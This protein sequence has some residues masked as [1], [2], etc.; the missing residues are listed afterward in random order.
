ME[1]SVL[2]DGRDGVVIVVVE[3]GRERRH[4][5]VLATDD[6]AATEAAVRAAPRRTACAPDRRGRAVSRLLMV[7]VVW[8][9]WRAM[10]VLLLSAAHV[11]HF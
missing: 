11:I 1:R 6:V 4:R 3:R 8:L 5:F 10:A 7:V 9:R 2:P